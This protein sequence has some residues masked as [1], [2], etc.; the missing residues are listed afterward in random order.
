M[1]AGVY[2]IIPM[3]ASA[4]RR[5]PEY[6]S[7]IDRFCLADSV[8]RLWL[9]PFVFDLA[10]AKRS[11][12]F[13]PYVKYVKNA[14]AFGIGGTLPTQIAGFTVSKRPSALGLIGVEQSLE[15]ILQQQE[16]EFVL[17]HEYSHILMNHS[18]Y[19][20]LGSYLSKQ[21]RDRI[22]RIQSKVLRMTV[23]MVWDS[24]ATRVTASFT[25]DSELVADA[26]ASQLVGSSSIARNAIE[27]LVRVYAGGNPDL[28]SHFE[29]KNGQ[30]VTILTYQERLD[31]L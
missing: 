31:A 15:N 30:I 12:A 3:T 20:Y 13:R 8:T 1:V 29:V 19:L 18:P 4:I 22:A 2:G 17:A 26:H 6:D 10:T 9:N 28:P 14:P 5:K 27:T 21:V 25:K 7:H 24:L 16:M 11:P 23:G